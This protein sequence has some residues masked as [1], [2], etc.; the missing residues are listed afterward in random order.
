MWFRRRGTT[1]KSKTDHTQSHLV[2]DGGND[3]GPRGECAQDVLHLWPLS[4]HGDGRGTGWDPGVHPW[5]DNS[6]SKTIRRPDAWGWG[7]DGWPGEVQKL[8][9]MEWSLGIGNCTPQVWSS[10]PSRAFQT[11]RVCGT[12]SVGG[13]LLGGGTI[14][15]ISRKESKSHPLS[16][17]FQTLPKASSPNCTRK[18]TKTDKENCRE[19]R[20]GIK[21]K[22]FGNNKAIK[23][24]CQKC[25]KM[26]NQKQNRSICG[27]SVT[28]FCVSFGRSQKNASQTNY[29]TNHLREIMIKLQ[30][31]KKSK[32]KTRVSSMI[33]CISWAHSNK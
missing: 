16:P 20:K 26:S 25:T 15:Q 6:V 7:W 33:L 21:K 10:L 9:G 14:H 17:L 1:R 32:S 8:A 29:E 13:R 3:V 28:L 4:I 31:K 24:A 27:A 23:N 18:C 2:V 12:M 11:R 5:G 30:K 19:R 22:H